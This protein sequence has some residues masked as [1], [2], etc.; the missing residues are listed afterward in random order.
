MRRCTSCVIP[1]SN[2][3]ISFD[4]DTCSLCSA[5]KR[6]ITTVKVVNDLDYYI[7]Q[8]KQT[9]RGRAFDCLVGISGGRDSAYLLNQLVKKH[10]LRCLGAYHRTPFTPD[11]IDSNVIRLT[12]KLH[13]PLIKMDISM[14][15]HRELAGK[16]IR[17][18]L[19][20]PLPVIA[21][22]ACAP[23]KQ[24]NKEI[25]EIAKN[26][27]VKYLIMGSNKYEA[28]QLT[29]GY[30][31]DNVDKISFITKIKQ[32]LMLLKKGGLALT[33]SVE[34][35]RF[36]LIGIK[37]VLYLSPDS[38]YL[39][40]RYPGTITFNYFY[41]TDWNEIECE[42]AL[43]ELGWQK[44][45][46]CN[47]SWRADCAFAEVKNYMFKKMTG[48]TYVDAFFSTLTREGVISRNEALQRV[49]TEGKPSLERLSEACNIM[50]LPT[51]LFI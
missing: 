32:L 38:P 16:V 41:H 15:Y 8:I 45:P 28:F 23:C 50:G 48:V 44:P 40:C 6:K 13:V 36:L 9:G 7:E 21:N 37:S 4:G 1:K 29:S 46:N 27:D 47:S 19:K 20:K 39:R 26:N 22:L 51:D 12:E 30:H 2:H 35:W 18:W 5:N 11:I 33:E 31:D 49:K 10:G 25:L 3:S 34:L 24:H 42:K 17:L 14:E 43:S